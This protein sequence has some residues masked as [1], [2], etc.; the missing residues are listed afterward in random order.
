MVWTHVKAVRTAHST[1]LTLQESL[2]YQRDKQTFISAHPEYRDPAL[3]RLRK[4]EFSRL[5]TRH[6]DSVYLD[7]T[8][9]ALA[10]ASLVRSAAD[11]LAS[12]VAGNPHSDSPASLTS[13]RALDEARRAVLDFFDADEAV[14]DVV[15]TPNA[16]GGFK[17][18]GES[19][20][21]AGKKAL[22]PRDAHNSL[23]GLAKYAELAG[24]GFEFVEFDAGD[25]ISRA[26]YQRGLAS[27]PKGLVFFTGQSNI[28][29][30]KLDLSLLVLAKQT[31]WDVGLDAAALAPSTR[32]SLG[33]LDNSVD[34][35]VVSLYKICGF[36]TGLG[37]LVLRKDAYAKLTRKKTFS[38]GNIMG[39]TMDRFDFTLVDGPERF[40][41]GTP[42]F[43]SM[44]AVKQGLEFAE[45]WRERSGKRNG[46]LIRWL[47][48][49]LDGI[50]YPPTPEEDE[51]EKRCSSSNTSSTTFGNQIKLVSNLAT[52]R[53]PTS[54]GHTLSLNL[55]S[56][57]GQSLNYRFVIFAAALSNISLRGGPCLC[58]P[59]ASSAVLDRG[60]ITDLAASTLLRDADVGLVRVSLGVPTNFRDVWRL[61]HFLRNLTVPEWR[62]DM[63]RRYEAQARGGTLCNNIDE[64]E[65]WA[66]RK[67]EA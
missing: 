21:W 22:I 17:I 59:G 3:T 13:S 1:S 19:Y 24:G 14:Y 31:G 40:E 32:I 61:V 46:L 51:V 4:R 18:V 29:S 50:Y 10:P 34:F 66:T 30:A 43:A 35:M 52:P 44:C 65:A 54:H 28:T 27:S 42:N 45:R 67:R 63:W 26:S 6:A 56:P 62:H 47:V 39:I 48:E 57:S 8:G 37:A 64:L 11:W 7:Y 60:L 2:S 36:P 9:A 20:D 53:S 23:N 12:H 41:D 15:W 16:T 25:L 49:Q 33:G 55:R 38:G 58:N 5:D